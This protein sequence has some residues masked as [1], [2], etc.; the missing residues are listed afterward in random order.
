MKFRAASASAPQSE[1]AHSAPAASVRVARRYP[2][3]PSRV[4]LSHNAVLTLAST[5]AGAAMALMVAIAAVALERPPD[6]ACPA[7]NSA[8]CHTHP[9]DWCMSLDGKVICVGEPN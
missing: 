7:G 4:W 8:P 2:S 3:G 5:A 6:A 9:V 1:R